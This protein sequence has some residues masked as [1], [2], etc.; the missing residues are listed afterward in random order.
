[1]IRRVRTKLTVAV[2]VSA[3]VIATA[4]LGGTADAAASTCRTTPSSS[5]AYTVKVCVVDPVA[6]ATLTGEAHALGTV[7]VP[8]GTSPGVARTE[9]SLNGAYLLT[10]YQLPHQFVVPTA[11]FADGSYTLGVAAV[12]RDGFRTPETTVTVSFANGNATTPENQRHWAPPQVAA[13]APNEPFV[14]TAVGDGAG[15]ETNAT[16]VTDQLVSW[17]PDLLLYLGDVY[18]DGTLTEFRNWYGDATSFFGR[19]RSITT[20]V[21]GNHEYTSG[22]APGY[23]QYW[24]NIGHYYSYDANGWHFIA[25]DSTS[26]YGKQHAPGTAQYD[27]LAGDLAANRS[28]CTVV[29]WHHPLYTVGSE[30][31]SPRMQPMWD[32]MASYKVTLQLSG[33]DHQYQRWTPMG[34]GG[35]P[36]SDGITEVVAGTGG[37]SVQPVTNP[38]EPRVLKSNKSYGAL[39]M[40]LFGNRADV[41]Y[42][43]T[44]PTTGTTQVDQ[45]T[46]TCKGADGLVPST[47]G[48]LAATEDTPG[49]VH[50]SWTA[51][52]DNFGV[53]G[54]RVYRDGSPVADLPAGTTSWADT[55]AA[56][57]HEYAY[58]VDAVDAAGNR[59][60]KSAP[61]SILTA[62]AD[63]TPPSTP[64]GLTA[65]PAAD[66]VTLTWTASTDNVGVT[67][68]EVLRDGSPLATAA[69]TSFTDTTV[70]ANEPH[71]WTVR[72][73]DAAGNASAESTAVSATRD[74]EA[75]S[76]PEGLHTTA[77]TAGSVGLAWT[78]ATDNLGVA[79]YHVY[80]DGLQ[81]ATVPDT[82]TS[83]TDET[84]GSAFAT[85]TYH[86]VA[87]DLA[88]NVSAPS[89]SVEV[90][91]VD[92]SPPT[93]PGDLV[94]TATG[95]NR[96]VVSWSP[97]SDDTGV[98]EYAVY[99]GPALLATTAGTT[100]TDTGVLSETAYS[101]TVVARDAAGNSSGAAGPSVV[102]TPTPP[103][104]APVADTYA[105][106]A[107]PTM[108]YGKATTVRVDT[109]PTNTYLK[110]TVSGLSGP[111]TRARLRIYTT[112]GTTPG[113]FA[114]GVA[115]T[116]WSET[117][118]TW[119]NAPAINGG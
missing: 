30:D 23:F 52:T 86:V 107:S 51:A 24:D 103:A 119:N 65:L 98:T 54:Y 83:Y 28:P 34:A 44:N 74:T 111:V 6:G 35:V 18:A 87:A 79:Y 64:T 41:R 77:V 50:L 33:H 20:P 22:Q 97:S 82:S 48:G 80:R 45:N 117:G 110:F 7:S 32:L 13:R 31:P 39:K 94:T 47:P 53:T 12:M 56:P 5:A 112:A 89:T 109:S 113:I 61:V 1:M 37:H 36:A 15:G 21:V 2:V 88:G 63:S 3:A 91:T 62:G 25:I 11:V 116:S 57:A 76:A 10:D 26:N 102:T 19:L 16:T 100:V 93:T 101:Y 67:G 27:W 68:Y 118:L 114:R 75:P 84:V 92:A 14:V 70:P 85:H 66:A 46:V 69:T 115:D 72:A 104:I 81:I 42:F 49:T 99:R 8:S 106:F 29:F 78:A 73:L 43:A 105:R 40:E 71:S 59:S 9:W 55:T 90:S 108:N 38:D 58:T 17:N 95:P 60:T 96:V 4:W